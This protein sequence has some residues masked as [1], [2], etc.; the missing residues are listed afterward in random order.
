MYIRF[1]VTDRDRDNLMLTAKHDPDVNKQAT[2]RNFGAYMCDVLDSRL[3]ELAVFFESIIH[4]FLRGKHGPGTVS[5]ELDS[6]PGLLTK[7][8]STLQ[9]DQ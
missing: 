4:T 5:R 6:L 1:N 9:P 2:G 8:N 3:H 7:S